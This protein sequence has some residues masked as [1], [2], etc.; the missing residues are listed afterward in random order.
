MGVTNTNLKRQIWGI[1][2]VFLI[3]RKGMW[4]TYHPVDKPVENAPSF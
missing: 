1:W 3:T 4:I 2:G